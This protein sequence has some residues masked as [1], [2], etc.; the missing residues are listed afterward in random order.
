MGLELLYTGIKPIIH[1]LVFIMP[2]R[3]TKPLPLSLGRSQPE[4]I[5]LKKGCI[6]EKNCNCRHRDFRHRAALCLDDLYE[7]HCF[8]SESR[9][10]GHTR[11]ITLPHGKETLAVDTGFIV[12]NHK[13]YPHLTAMLD[14][15][16]IETCKSNMSFGVSA[17]TG[18]IE[19]GT[20]H[21]PHL[22]WHPKLR[23]HKAYWR[24][25]IDII[26]FNF[27][28]K[29]FLRKNAWINHLR[30][31]SIS[32]TLAH[33][34]K[35]SF[36][37]PMA[38]SIWSTPLE[39]IDHFSTQS[40][41]EF[42][43]NHGLLTLFRQPQWYSIKNGSHQYI[44]AFEKHFK[45]HLHTS[46]KIIQIQSTQH[47]VYLTDNKAQDHTFDHVIF[48]CHSDQA[49]SCLAEHHPDKAH[50]LKHMPYQSNHVVF[51]S[52]TRF[53][54]ND[55]N[56]WASWVYLQDHSNPKAISLTYWM[57]HLQDL[58]QNPPYLVTLNPQSPPNP[59]LTYDEC[60]LSHPKMSSNT[61]AHQASIEAI[62][63]Q[64]HIDFAGAWLGH[65]FHEDGLA[66]GI[67]AAKRLGGK[68]PW[69]S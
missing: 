34:F 57:N 64:D 51:H 47:G 48:A 39:Q 6:D 44:K 11:T 24:M 50:L 37:R 41:L 2:P 7:V 17:N 21:I 30:R 13:N 38:G 29:A 32:T 26:R 31:L 55:K 19:Y 42:F 43:D 5:H 14:Y 8:E 10:G 18:A 15:F 20:D 63:G 66:S 60:I 4:L 28:G 52:D 1:P 45:G 12:F 9:L 49:A 22:L 67:R 46:T 62:Q 25:L 59:E 54:P 23:G 56:A 16:S 40:L 65:G 35:I 36:L 53:M 69:T 61:S 58:P 27:H 68:P 3:T 33:G